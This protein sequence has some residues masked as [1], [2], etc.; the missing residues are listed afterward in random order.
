MQLMH[1]LS[2]N[3]H[4]TLKSTGWHDHCQR[5]FLNNDQGSNHLFQS[6]FQSKILGNKTSTTVT[7]TISHSSGI[8]VKRLMTL[9]PQHCLL[10]TPVD[11]GDGQD[12]SI[13]SSLPWLLQLSLDHHYQGMLQSHGG[14]ATLLCWRLALQSAQH[15]LPS[16]CVLDETISLSRPFPNAQLGL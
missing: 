7:F 15:H 6:M 13:P 1:S 3:M 5:L 10:H 12:A 2:N 16:G 9:M 4:K 11:T 8:T 14:E